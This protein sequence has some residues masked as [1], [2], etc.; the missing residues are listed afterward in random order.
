M[1][2]LH[3]NSR[4]VTK[5]GEDIMI[6][7]EYTAFNINEKWGLM[8][9]NGKVVIMAQYTDIEA[10]EKNIFSCQLGDYWITVDAKGKIIH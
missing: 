9:K 10:L 8:D 2:E 7:S 6:R 5:E 4:Q 3:Y 1:K